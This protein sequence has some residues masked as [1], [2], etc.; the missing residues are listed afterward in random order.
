[1]SDHFDPDPGAFDDGSDATDLDWLDE[2]VDDWAVQPEPDP[3]ASDDSTDARSFAPDSSGS[4][5]PPGSLLDDS[6][7]SS[8]PIDLDVPDAGDDGVAARLPGDVDTSVLHDALSEIGAPDAAA[9]IAGLDETELEPRAAVG[10]LDASGIAAR[11]E[12]ADIGSLVEAV[13]S[14]RDVLLVGAPAP[15]AVVSVDVPNGSVEL[16]GP[17]GPITVSLDDLAD[18]WADLDHEAVTVPSAG[19]PV[20]LGGDAL[21]LAV[22]PTDLPVRPI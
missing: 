21:L 18:A 4:V 16:D 11:V 14:G 1:M 19:G 6:D 22:D 10:A 3:P 13:T 15:Y 12:H 8:G 9:V 5:E 2:L 7:H 17:D 20:Q